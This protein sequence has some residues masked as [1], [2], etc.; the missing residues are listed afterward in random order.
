MPAKSFWYKIKRENLMRYKF[1]G[2]ATTALV[3]FGA[4]GVYAGG[5]EV[6]RLPTDM[7]F[8]DGNYASISYGSFKPDVTDDTYATV[9]SMYKDR[10]AVTVTIKSQIN[11][12]I[13]LG[14]AS[15]KS[16]EIQLDYSDA[17]LFFANLPAAA[18]GPLPNPY[19]DLSVQT[20]AFLGRYEV[21]ENV[22]VIGGLKYTKGSGGGNVLSS[23]AGIIAAEDDSVVG[24][25]IGASY[26]KPE[27]ALRISG[28]YQAKQDMEH[29][30]TTDVDE[31]LAM[32]P[33]T[34]SL[35][36]S[37]TLNFQSG[38]APNTLLFGSIHRALWGDAHIS[39]WSNAGLQGGT[40]GD[41]G[42]TGYVQKTTWTDTTS[43]SLGIGRKLSDEWAISASLNHE[44]P[45]EA[46]GTSLLSTTDGV[47]G[48]SSPK[49]E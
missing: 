14:F 18:G 24:A 32:E 31:T 25:I 7:M 5:M 11:D 38:I 21:V 16:A 10:S 23:P 49:T 45:S 48:L 22:S 47:S 42:G 35:P 6:S 28:F 30:T 2:L 8:E 37:F 9:G 34:S 3:F 17:S 15:Y 44:A 40:D 33:T 29:A 41:G 39:F 36:A 27:I 4:S 13:S 43:L 46:E 19:V 20:M 26:E 1:I 12:K